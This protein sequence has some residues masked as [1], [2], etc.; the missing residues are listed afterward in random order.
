MASLLVVGAGACVADEA[1]GTAELALGGPS[2]AISVGSTTVE[3]NPL[4]P[5]RTVTITGYPHQPVVVTLD[6]A[7]AGALDTSTLTLDSEG[8]GS[9]VFTPCAGVARTCLGPATI[10]LSL[11]RAQTEVASQS[12]TLVYPAQVGDVAPCQGNSNV[13]YLRGNDWVMNGTYQSPADAAWAPFVATN[14]VTF[15]VGL[16]TSPDRFVGRFSLFQ[17]QQPLTPGIYDNAAREAFAL[18]G[19]PGIDVSGRSHGC[20]IIAG[21]FQVHDYSADPAPDAYTSGTLH[22]ATISFEQ[23]CDPEPDFTGLPTT[24]LMVGCFHYDENAASP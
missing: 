15:E 17:L 20:N 22:H 14:Q 3:A 18:P 12:F 7:T 16:V 5:A 2:F 8:R 21:R 4:L 10:R 9:V 1:T 24:K 23:A 6:R 13:M 11:G 19:Q